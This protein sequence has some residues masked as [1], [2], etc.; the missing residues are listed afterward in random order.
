MS[1]DGSVTHWFEDI[2]QG[3]SAA[4]EALWHRYFPRLVLLARQHLQARGTPKGMADEED[5]ALSALDS[6]YRA[7]QKGRFPDLADRHG[8]WRLLLRITA[9]KVIDLT[10]HETRKRRGGRGVRRESP[11][12]RTNPAHEE[13]GLDGLIGNEPTPEFAAMVAEQCRRLLEQLQDPDL[14]SLALAKMEGYGNRQ[15][16]EQLDCS[17]RTV[18]RRLQLIRKTWEQEYPP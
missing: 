13:P 11:A 18:E 12:D 3:D 6:F 5:I 10:R 8:L 4:A 9:R 16:A 1:S 17:V 7:A 15:I 14:Q 2:K